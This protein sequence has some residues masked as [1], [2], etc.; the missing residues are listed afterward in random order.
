M[1]PAAEKIQLSP[2]HLVELRQT[3]VLISGPAAAEKLSLNG[4]FFVHQFSKMAEN[5]S[6][7][8]ARVILG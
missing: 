5:C 3:G 7:T 6:I 1:D 8:L 4:M 2:I